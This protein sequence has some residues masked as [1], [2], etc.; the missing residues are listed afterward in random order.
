[1]SE[2]TIIFILVVW[3]CV[4]LPLS[5]RGTYLFLKSEWNF[6]NDK[7]IKL[8]KRSSGFYTGVGNFVSY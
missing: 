5:I 3:F 8:T 6:R 7:K 1:M 2:S 4:M